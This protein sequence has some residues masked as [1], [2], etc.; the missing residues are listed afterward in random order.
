MALPAAAQAST[1]LSAS[2][3]GWGTNWTT[4]EAAANNNAYNALYD[5]ARAQ[6]E[7]CANVTYADSLYYIVPG[8][9]GYVF[10]ATATGT[11]A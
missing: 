6:G 2:A 10:S 5:L 1:V 7:T 3:T 11:C 9:G 4:A 8:G